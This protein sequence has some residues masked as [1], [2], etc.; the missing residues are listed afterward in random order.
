MSAEDGV[1]HGVYIWKFKTAEYRQEMLDFLSTNEKGF[2]LTRKWKG[3]I[4]LECRYSMD[5]EESLFMWGKYESKAD[6][7][8]YVKMR[9]ET[10]FFKPWMEKMSAPPVMMQLSNKS[11]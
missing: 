7:H 9:Q 5:D 10:E 2:Q 8:S 11:I 6:Y 4:S 1:Y 3:F